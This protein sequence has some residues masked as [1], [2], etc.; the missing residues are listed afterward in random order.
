[1]RRAVRLPAA[2]PTMCTHIRSR[3][4]A[5]AAGLAVAA[6][7]GQSSAASASCGREPSV[8]VTVEGGTLTAREGA[9][10]QAQLAADLA[11]KG[12]AVCA[13][14]RAAEPPI[15]RLSASRKAGAALVVELHVIDEITSKTLRRTVDLARIPADARA[16]ALGAAAG[17]LLRASWLE[18]LTAPAPEAAPPSPTPVAAPQSVRELARERLAG[19]P[20]SRDPRFE[21]GVHANYDVYGWGQRQWG[22]TLWATWAPT[23]SLALE[24]RAGPRQGLAHDATHG[25]VTSQGLQAGASVRW[26][27]LPPA[28][29][30]RPS[31]GAGVDLLY[32]AFR[33]EPARDAVGAR[34]SSQALT[35]AFETRLA[36]R[37]YRGWTAVAALRGGSVLQAIEVRDD[38][39]RTT[40]VGGLVVG[41]SLGVAVSF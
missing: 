28:A 21:L 27:V 37:V 25:T 10:F 7:A 13:P 38:T 23:Q 39:A 33:G 31:F 29:A 6:A 32:A 26:E 24:L 20:S 16:L 36:A 22:P 15:A 1:M 18:A 8:E 19:A 2:G 3:F 12:V 9:A 35:V 4:V 40:G 14:Q 5:A 34:Q 41:A 11:P 17:E 30:L